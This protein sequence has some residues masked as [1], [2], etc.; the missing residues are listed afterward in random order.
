[1]T[2]T[3]FSLIK[4]AEAEVLPLTG[5]R[6]NVEVLGGEEHDRAEVTLD[7]EAVADHVLQRV[8]SQRVGLFVGLVAADLAGE[9]VIHLLDPAWVQFRSLPPIFPI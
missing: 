5:V 8:V 4:A 1:M 9:L 7:A 2:I 6:V 3:N